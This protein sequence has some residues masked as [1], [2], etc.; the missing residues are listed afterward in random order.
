[1]AYRGGRRLDWAVLILFVCASGAEAIERGDI[2]ITE[3]MI[4]PA[5]VPDLNGEY[6]EL[7]NTTGAAIDINGW[8]LVDH[9]RDEHTIMSEAPLVLEPGGCAVLARGCDPA[10]N[11]GLPSCQY[12]YANIRLSNGED[13]VLLI[14]ENDVV[15]EVVYR[16]DEGFPIVPG[17]A[18]EL[19][20]P[21]LSNDDPANWRPSLT[22]FGAGDFGSPGLCPSPTSVHGDTWAHVKREWWPGAL[23]GRP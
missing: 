5:S 13:E 1:M 11:G 12:A 14:F 17:A 9:G 16:R 15:D 20:D 18:T 2:V 6:I 4:D 3:L 10:L 8:V 23:E 7:Y 19:R 22:S 21:H